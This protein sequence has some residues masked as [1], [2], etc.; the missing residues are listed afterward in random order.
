MACFNSRNCIYWLLGTEPRGFIKC[1]L[2]IIT[3]DLGIYYPEKNP[4]ETS[5]PIV[6][7]DELCPFGVEPGSG[8]YWP[9]SPYG[10]EYGPCLARAPMIGFEY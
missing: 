4:M 6:Q 9:G 1:H 7:R 10:A 8:M 5:I 2:R 3:E